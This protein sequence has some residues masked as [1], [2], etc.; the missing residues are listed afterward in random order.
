MEWVPM[1]FPILAIIICFVWFKSKTLWW[2]PIIPLVIVAVFI[3]IF[4]FAAEGTLTSDTEYWSGHVTKAEFFEQWDER[5]SCRHPKYCTRTVTRGSG[6]NRHTT[7]EQY[8]CGYHHSYDVDHHPKRWRK[9]DNN[10]ISRSISQTEFIKYTKLFGNKSF[11]D[12][13]R[14]YH[15]YDG[16][17]YQSNWPGSDETID[18]LV[19]SHNYENR[20]QASHSVFNFPEVDTTDIKRFKLFDYPSIQRNDHQLH[21]LG[22]TN[23][24][25][26]RKLEILNAK[27]GKKKQVSAMVAVYD[28][29]ITAAESQEAYWKGGNKNEFIVCVGLDKNKPKAKWV[30][31]ISWNLN[32]TLNVKVRNY[33]MKQDTLDMSKLVDFMYI[34][35]DSHF[36]RQP[37]AEFSYLKVELTSGQMLAIWITSFLISLGLGIWIVLNP[38]DEENP[39]GSR[40]N[41]YRY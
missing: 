4:K 1:I 22:M 11:V 13:H 26:E 35:I 31:I 21:L 16:D 34:E 40:Y 28:G 12:L 15:S 10:G 6:K 23:K 17:K 39:S 32:K 27:L 38:M 3:L 7:T 9:S 41:R 20:V 37:F 8:Q 29:P 33:V 19:S 36:E 18:I 25:V 2:E 30:H 24:K 5:V 14:N